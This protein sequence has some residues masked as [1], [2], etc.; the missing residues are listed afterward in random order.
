MPLS[1]FIVEHMLKIIKFIL[2]IAVFFYL[3]PTADAARKSRQKKKRAPVAQGVS[4][5]AAIAWN[6]TQ[7]KIYFAKNAD[8][9]VFPA[10]TTK[11]MM[12][13]VALEKL[14]LDQYVTVSQRATR[15]PPTKLYLRPGEQYRVRDL[16]Y[17]CM[18]KSAN[19]AAVVL[20]EA[21]GGSEAQFVAMMNQKA[22]AIGAKNTRFANSHGLPSVD[23]QYTTARDM[24]VIFREAMKN[25]FF[26]EASRV[27]YKNIYSKNG[28]QHF[29]KSHNKAFF[30]KWKQGVY[31]KTGYTLQAQSCFVGYLKKGSDVIIVN[32]FGCRTQK[33]WNDIKWMIERRAGVNL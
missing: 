14:S 3:T 28:R 21:A 11:V 15:E 6:I 27:A 17:A 13:L 12:M 32:V 16:I 1:C 24:A 5:K 29:L 7:D 22:Q 23:K 8:Q 9:R 30:L 4:A 20:A 19:D 26:Q 31:G 2:L 10:S 25:P 18:L 33:R